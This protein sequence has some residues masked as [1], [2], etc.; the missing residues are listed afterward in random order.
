MIDKR[1]CESCGEEF[2][3]NI[4][5]VGGIDRCSICLQMNSILSEDWDKKFL[6][7]LNFRTSLE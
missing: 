5:K 7:R 2:V 6:E 3:P 1:L 4:L